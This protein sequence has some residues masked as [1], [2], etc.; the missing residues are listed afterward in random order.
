M[1]PET[2]ASAMPTFADG[3]DRSSVAVTTRA[4]G[5][6]QLTLGG[7][8]LYTF[9]GDARPGDRNGQGSGGVWFVIGADG[10]LIEA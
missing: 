9:S 2:A 8:P 5:S 1:V 10:Q 3:N 4:D 7:W 6:A